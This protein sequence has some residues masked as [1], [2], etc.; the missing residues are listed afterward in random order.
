[1]TPESIPDAWLNAF[2]R[3]D[4]IDPIIRE[5]LRPIYDRLKADAPEQASSFALAMIC[6]ALRMIESPPGSP[7]SRDELRRG[8]ASMASAYVESFPEHP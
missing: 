2:R 1:M 7:I 3:A 8:L 6:R 4:E 5:A